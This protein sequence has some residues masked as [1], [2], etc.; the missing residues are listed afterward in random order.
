MFVS[1]VKF[2]V[3]VLIKVIFRLWDKC[4]NEWLSVYVRKKV[5]SERIE[6]NDYSNKEF[7]ILVEKISIFF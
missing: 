1:V 6:I 7:K 2:F 5:V 3:D 4:F